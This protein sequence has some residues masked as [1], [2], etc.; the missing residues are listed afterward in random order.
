MT[1]GSSDDEADALL[2]SAALEGRSMQDVACPAVS[3]YVETNSRAELLDQVLDQELPRYAE[4]LEH[5]GPVSYLTR[6]IFIY[7]AERA[8]GERP[9]V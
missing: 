1:R 6:L 4:A 8:A 5:L 3:E 2:R 9:V 7:V